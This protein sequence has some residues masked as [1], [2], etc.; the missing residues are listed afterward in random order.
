MLARHNL[1]AGEAARGS[2]LI[3]A[4]IL[5]ALATLL[6]TKL[7]FEEW[8]EQRRTIG[9]L[10]A[11][12]ALHFGLGAEALAADVLSQTAQGGGG[13]AGPRTPAPKAPKAAKRAARRSPWP[14]PGRNPPSHC[15]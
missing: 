14:S 11:E 12:Q 7:T 4:L 1:D 5:V 13:A 9:V 2:R 15:R 8:L 6:A 3:I 10:A